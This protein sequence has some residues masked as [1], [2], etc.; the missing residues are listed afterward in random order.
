MK[1]IKKIIIQNII[2]MNQKK[3][4]KLMNLKK[5]SQMKILMNK[6]KILIILK[7]II[8]NFK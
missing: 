8:M 6:K 2:I 7:I 4:L 5:M 1:I 3:M